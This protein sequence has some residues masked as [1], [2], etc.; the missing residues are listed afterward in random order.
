[1]FR[2]SK[3]VTPVVATVLLLFIAV[4]AVGS[5]AVFLEGTVQSI[6]DGA[7]SELRQEDRIRDSEIRIES[8]FNNSDDNLSIEVRNSGS[9]SIPVNESGETVWSIFV[10]DVP[11]NDWSIEG[12]TVEEINPNQIIT[13]DTERPFPDE[14]ESDTVRITAPYETTDSHVCFNT[15]SLRC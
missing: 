11:N 5:A 7:E 15:G 9:I 2:K 10:D 12:G 4:A 6:Q 1:M 3:G 14:G 8:G 13:I